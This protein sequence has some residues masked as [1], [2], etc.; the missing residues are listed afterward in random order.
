MGQ[1]ELTERA[2]EAQCGKDLGAGHMDTDMDTH[3]QVTDVLTVEELW[4]QVTW[5][6]EGEEGPGEMPTLFPSASSYLLAFR[7]LKFTQ[8][9]LHLK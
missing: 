5:R 9:Y 8:A 7:F 2:G 1:T 4:E 3:T 6:L